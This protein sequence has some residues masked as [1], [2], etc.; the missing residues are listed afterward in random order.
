MV[1]FT[2]LRTAVSDCLHL[3]A[4]KLFSWLEAFN[5]LEAMQVENLVELVENLPQLLLQL[6]KIVQKFGI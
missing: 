4:K 2:D 6:R 5:I 3:T 1:S